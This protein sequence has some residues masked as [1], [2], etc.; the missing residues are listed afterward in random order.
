MVRRSSISAVIAVLV[1]AGLYFAFR[2]AAPRHSSDQPQAS[3][4]HLTIQGER[5][6]SGP[7][8]IV[9][10]QGDR[11]TLFVTADRAG[12][13]HIHGYGQEIAL[14]SGREAAL[15]F[16]ADRAGRYGIDLHGAGGAHA[17]V[18]VLEVQP[19]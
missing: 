8:L 18:A 17:E 10:T 7:E 16:S 3:T 4:Y 12:S 1:L 19:R 2:N 5:V 9:A 11:V 6:V 14:E 13:L 15:A